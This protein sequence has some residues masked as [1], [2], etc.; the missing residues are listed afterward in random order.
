[1][2]ISFLDIYRELTDKRIM[3]YVKMRSNGACGK[4]RDTIGFAFFSFAEHYDLRSGE[5]N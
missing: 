3:F 1:M 2:P 5:I 4:D